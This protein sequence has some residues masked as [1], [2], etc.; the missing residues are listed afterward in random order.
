LFVETNDSNRVREQVVIED[1]A[2][3][4]R[5][6][7]RTVEVMARGDTT[8][9]GELYDR[10]ARAVYSLALRVVSNQADAEEVVQDVFT[11]AWRQSAR[12]DDSRASVSGWLLMMARARAIDRLRARQSRP[13]A[14]A[15]DAALPNIPEAAPDQEIRAIDRQT[16]QSLKG[17]LGTLPEILRTPIE[18]AYYEGLSHS[19]IA[20]RLG[21]PL[22][23]VKT[24]VRTALLRLRGVLYQDGGR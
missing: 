3:Q 9:L 23:T 6:D 21:E 12:Y 18:L 11:Q 22:G 19:A 14:V 17:A 4:A 20:E 8:A 1:G 13:D 15:G 10:Y 16:A 24:R 7:R 2:E 5:A